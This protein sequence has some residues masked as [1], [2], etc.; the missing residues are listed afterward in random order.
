MGVRR[1]LKLKRRPEH[2]LKG[3][4]ATLGKLEKSHE[5]G[6]RDAG[7]VFQ[8]VLCLALEQAYRRGFA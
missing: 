6:D 4:M 5:L 2:V 8:S 3:A 7:P 1:V